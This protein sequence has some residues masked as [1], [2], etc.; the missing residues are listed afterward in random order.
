MNSG[1]SIIPNAIQFGNFVIP[2]Y[3]LFVFVGIVAFALTSFFILKHREHVSNETLIRLTL[4]SV[5]A[6]I[7]LYVSA[8][9]FDSIFHSIEEGSFHFGGI[10][11]L[12]GV[13][14]LFPVLWVLIHFFVPAGRGK[15]FEF[16]SYLL[17]GIVIGHAFGRVGCFFGGCCYG[18]VTD[19]PIGVRYPFGSAAA[20]RYPDMNLEGLASLPVLPTQLFEAGFDGILA[21]IMLVLPKKTRVYDFEIYGFAYSVWRFILEFFR[22]DDRGAT[23]V[24]ISPSQMMSILLFLAAIFT[25]LMRKGIWIPGYK[26]RS[27]YW[28]AN[29]IKPKVRKDNQVAAFEQL[30]EL[31]AK[32]LISEEE[33]NEKRKQLIDNIGNGGNKN[34]TEN[35]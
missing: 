30:E 24:V 20:T 16:I 17:P 13:L 15:E 12:G 28:K 1:I 19:L 22:G 5:P 18:A 26:K 10:T 4:I 3:G 9:L 27:E 21:I 2:F 33:Y 23:G 35:K 7:A 32:G 14:G 25:L 29:P 6:L 11:W 34:A 31:K 8:L